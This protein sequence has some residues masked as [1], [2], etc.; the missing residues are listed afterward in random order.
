MR[1]PQ[2]AKLDVLIADLIAYLSAG[3]VAPLVD[4]RPARRDHGVI[5]DARAHAVR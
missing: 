1:R 4:R 3:L 5:G 2:R